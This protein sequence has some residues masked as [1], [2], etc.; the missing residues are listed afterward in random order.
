MTFSFLVPVYNAERYL[1]RCL[2]S[3]LS[4]TDRDFE[5]VVVD[6]ASPGN[7]AE[8]VRPYGAAVRYV[9]H[10]RNRS[11]F[12]ARRTG[13]LAAKGDY[14]VPVDPDDYLLP[15]V[16]QR[17]RRLIEA[18]RPDVIAYRMEYDTG[19]RIRRHWFAPSERTVDAATALAALSEGRFLTGVACKILRRDTAVRALTALAA[20]EDAYLNTSDDYLL[21]MAVLLVSE[22]M[23][24]L[25]YVGYRYFM[26]EAS[27]SHSW[28]SD[29]GL[30]RAC[31]QTRT[32]N[33]LVRGLV[34]SLPADVDGIRQ[35]V[36]RVCVRME[37]W[38]VQGAVDGCAEIS[39]LRRQTL[40]R[41]FDAENVC[42]EL[43]DRLSL[44]KSSLAYRV[45]VRLA[46]PV[47]F[48]RKVLRRG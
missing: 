21:L 38:F 13:I 10:E 44:V 17:A 40:L 19:K 16:L 11:A 22:K 12:Q 23:S 27:T 33:D 31:R 48:M 43:F 24:F 20:P 7:C 9:R 46:A 34:A 29:E 25:D 41:W 26:R 32:A 30:E 14:V 45:G 37:R 28:D 18:E 42:L 8:V 39:P 1:P 5:I 2:D 3:L 6:D 15:E 35:S 36:E 4:Q 47:R